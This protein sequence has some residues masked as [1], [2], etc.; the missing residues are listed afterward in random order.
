M[1]EELRYLRHKTFYIHSRIEASLDYLII[2]GLMSHLV[3]KTTDLE[4]RYTNKKLQKIL[5]EL[6][7]SKKLDLSLS[8]FQ[9]NK[10]LYNKIRAINTLR[11]KLAHVLNNNEEIATLNKPENYIKALETITDAMDDMNKLFEKLLT[12]MKG[13]RV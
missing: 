9:I 10:A 3:H 4:N 5:K 1:D 6:N 2:K 7:F 12:K 11:N 8:L 13:K